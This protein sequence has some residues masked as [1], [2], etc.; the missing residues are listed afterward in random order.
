MDKVTKKR[1]NLYIDSQLLEF[2]KRF[3]YVTGS[4]ISNLVEGFLRSE[5][6]KTRILSAQRYLEFNDNQAEEWYNFSGKRAFDEADSINE[7]L[8]D[9]EEVKYCRDNPKSVRA[10]L[11]IQLLKEK[12]ERDQ[13]ELHQRAIAEEQRDQERQAFI[14]RWNETFK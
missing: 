12:Q 7:Y 11:R 6:E 5:E 10:K 13:L 1:V 9:E 2:S 3:S 4:S 8:H 14:K